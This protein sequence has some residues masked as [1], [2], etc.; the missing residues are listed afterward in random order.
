MGQMLLGRAGKGGLVVKGVS[1]SVKTN[2]TSLI[3]WLALLWT[4]HETS[5]TSVLDFYSKTI[6]AATY[7]SE[8]T[9]LSTLINILAIQLLGSRRIP[10][11]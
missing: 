1:A 6:N 5:A 2:T 11:T 8:G 3:D 10:K 4:L 9:S 7:I